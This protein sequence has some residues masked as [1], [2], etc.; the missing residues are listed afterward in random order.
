MKKKY[1]VRIT[2]VTKLLVNNSNYKI[3]DRNSCKNPFIFKLK[4]YKIPVNRG[5]C[6]RNIL[7]ILFSKTKIIAIINRCCDKKI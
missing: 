3:V 1:E 7:L 6:L 4:L 2:I 5:S